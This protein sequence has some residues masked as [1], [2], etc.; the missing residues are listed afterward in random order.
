MDWPDVCRLGVT[1]CI[2]KGEEGDEED[3]EENELVM[4]DAGNTSSSQ[5]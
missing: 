2:P 3:W 1:S 5:M 4:R